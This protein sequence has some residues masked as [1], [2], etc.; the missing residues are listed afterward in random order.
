M[1]CPQKP[2]RWKSAGRPCVASSARWHRTCPV[3]GV[4]AL[5]GMGKTSRK[6]ASASASCAQEAPRARSSNCPKKLLLVAVKVANEA[7]AQST[8]N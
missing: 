2:E 8:P 4:S 5:A 6:L 1:P 3:T 7:Y